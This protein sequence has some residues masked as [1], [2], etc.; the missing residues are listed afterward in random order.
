MSHQLLIV[1]ALAIPFP[2]KVF[3]LAS[4]DLHN[5]GIMVISY[6]LKVGLKDRNTQLLN[7]RTQAPKGGCN[8][9][10]YL[11][12]FALGLVAKCFKQKNLLEILPE[13]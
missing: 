6:T 9:F 5:M 3:E 4:L 2:R 1:F 13:N 7:C 8:K 11:N 12:Q 10:Q